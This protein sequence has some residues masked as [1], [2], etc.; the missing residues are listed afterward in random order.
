M[1]GTTD[2][3]IKTWLKETLSNGAVRSYDDVAVLSFY[4][5]DV[6]G[7]QGER[8][9]FY[10]MMVNLASY[11]A[12]LVARL[13]PLVPEY[14]SWF[15]IIQ[16]KKLFQGTFFLQ[17][18]IDKLILKQLLADEATMR[19]GKTPSLLGKWLPR[20]GNKY[21]W[22]AKELASYIW[23][24]DADGRMET[25][26]MA[27]YRKRCSAL[28]RALKTVEVLECG[29]RWSEI[30]FCDV[31]I[32]AI[33]SKWRAYMNLAENS[34]LLR[35]PASVDRNR[36]RDNFRE[37]FYSNCRLPK[38]V[39]PGRYDAVRKVVAEWSEGGWRVL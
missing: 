4:T 28:N 22:I 24:N 18:E 10:M 2:A 14:G 1:R 16:L 34:G 5:R 29:N 30:N 26:Y 23:D 13:I 32:G 7:G 33:K 17:T 3:E 11:D 20:E 21:G 38:G 31:P 35:H 27:S 39:E 19:A 15:D 9:V 37:F 36:C 12:D 25:N 8:D 6:R